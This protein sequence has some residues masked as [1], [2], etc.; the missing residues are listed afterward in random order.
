MDINGAIA[1]FAVDV[2]GRAEAKC[3]DAPLCRCLGCF[4][5][6]SFESGIGESASNV[7]MVGK[8]ERNCRAAS[9]GRAKFADVA[10]HVG[11]VW[12]QEGDIQ[13]IIG[14]E[15]EI[16]VLQV[17]EMLRVGKC[18]GVELRYALDTS[19]SIEAVGVFWNGARNLYEAA[20]FDRLWQGMRGDD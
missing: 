16:L 6:Q 3:L 15:P 9:Q 14:V 7:R 18:S 13:A 19:V 4:L 8:H 20:A 2:F 1:F 17:D 5:T 10:L 12:P 11:T